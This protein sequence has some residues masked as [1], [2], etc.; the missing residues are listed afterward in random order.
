MKAIDTKTTLA[1]Q[2][3]YLM[4]RYEFT[5][6]NFMIVWIE[7]EY[8]VEKSHMVNIIIYEGHRTGIRDNTGN[9][10]TTWIKRRESRAVNRDYYR[11]YELTQDEIDRHLIMEAL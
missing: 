10:Y 6:K 8:V 9:F 7:R 3:F 1:P 5:C 4:H 2:N 11:F